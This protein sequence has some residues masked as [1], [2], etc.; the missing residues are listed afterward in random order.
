MRAFADYVYP[1]PEFASKKGLAFRY[2][3]DAS[4]LGVSHT[5]LTVPINEYFVSESEDAA[6]FDHCGRT[7]YSI[8]RALPHL[9]IR[10]APTRRRG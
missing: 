4:A 8:R 3:S 1:Y 9:I 10:S 2:L 7:Y 5:V 6:F